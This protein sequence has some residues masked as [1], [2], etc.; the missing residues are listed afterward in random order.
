LIALENHPTQLKLT[1]RK[2]MKEAFRQDKTVN[3]ILLSATLTLDL[4]LSI[5]SFT[6]RNFE[7]REFSLS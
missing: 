7:M 2:T 3:P 5:M 6:R 1:D 4:N